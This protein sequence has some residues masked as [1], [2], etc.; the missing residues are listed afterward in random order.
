MN[1]PRKHYLRSL[2]ARKIALSR[3]SN[4]PISIAILRT[5]PYDALLAQDTWCIRQGPGKL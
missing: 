5:A 1:T 4:L 2:Q 3:A